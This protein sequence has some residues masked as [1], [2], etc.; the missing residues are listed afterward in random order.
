MLALQ[1]HTLQDQG[2]TP[3]GCAHLAAVTAVALGAAAP[4]LAAEGPASKD[5][6]K[7]GRQAVVPQHP[8][9]DH[10]G[11]NDVRQQHNCCSDCHPLGA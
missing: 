11:I 5:A 6:S 7:D 3:A 10:D 4:Q 2:A 1:P 8:A 9:E